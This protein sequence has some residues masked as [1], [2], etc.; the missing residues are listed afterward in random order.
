M[1]S[2]SVGAKDLQIELVEGTVY[3]FT[4]IETGQPVFGIGS[5]GK[6]FPST[7]AASPTRSS[8]TPKAMPTWK[9]TCSSASKSPTWPDLIRSLSATP[10]SATFAEAP[11][12]G[13][14]R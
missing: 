11:T 6:K 4:A 8:S 13:L 2:G 12:L 7:G 10:T 5:D 9:M 14:R 1:R 3:R